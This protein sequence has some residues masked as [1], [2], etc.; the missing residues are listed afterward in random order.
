VA[1]IFAWLSKINKRPRLFLQGEIFGPLNLSKM[2]IV[3]IGS[4]VI[5]HERSERSERSEVKRYQKQA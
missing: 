5:L 2:K 4:N 3:Q 1:D